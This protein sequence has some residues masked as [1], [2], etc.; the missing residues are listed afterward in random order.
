MGQLHDSLRRARAQG[1]T[2]HE[3]HAW[4]TSAERTGRRALAGASSVEIVALLDVDPGRG[5]ETLSD[6]AMQSTPCRAVLGREGSGWRRVDAPPENALTQ[7]TRLPELLSGF[8]SLPG[9]SRWLLWLTEPVR[10]DRHAVASIAEAAAMAPQARII[11]ADDDERVDRSHRVPR[12]KPA[13]DRER[14]MEL[15]YV[16]PVIA[17]HA[18]F[19]DALE[20]GGATVAAARWSLLIEASWQW[21]EDAVV[22]LPRLVSHR[23]LVAADPPASLGDVAEALDAAAAHRGTCVYINRQN[24]QL[25]YESLAPGDIASIVIPTRDR[26]PLLRRC[27]ESLVAR[28]PSPRFELVIVDNGTT[29]IS[30]RSYIASLADRLNAKVIDGA[31]PFNFARLC[32]L[33]VGASSGAIVVL[34]NNDTHVL[35]G[36]W[37]DELT[38]VARRPDVGAVGPLLQYDDGVIQ[39]AGVFLGVNRTSTN[40][41]A[42]YKPDNPHVAEWCTTRRRVSAVVGACLAVERRKYLS[43]GG[44]NEIFAV[45]HNELDLCL[46][47]EAAGYSNVFTPF[48]RVVHTEGGTRGYELTDD[49]L[50]RRRIEEAHFRKMW[51]RVLNYPDPAHNP[52]LARQGDPFRLQPRAQPPAR[53]GWRA[54]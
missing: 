30:A 47:L 34:L 5:E 11:Y 9:T 27:V 13:W 29:D 52:N 24:T 41:L 45:S 31:G 40:I 20:R 36:G 7:C 25:H 12:F 33:G 17:L 22:H 10:L 26:L 44:M 18:T 53:G 21:P 6:L 2:E 14:I 48:A 38:A 19:V 39:A 54:S 4:V 15:D 28:T 16:G 46:R 35:D 32:N 42:G 49:E 23:G 50:Q 37:L 1:F 3:F 43:V 8:S 51:A